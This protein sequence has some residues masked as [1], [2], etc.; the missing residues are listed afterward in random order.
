M[1]FGNEKIYRVPGRIHE[2]LSKPKHIGCVKISSMSL[3]EINIL[4]S[5][6]SDDSSREKNFDSITLSSVVIHF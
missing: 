1:N 5:Y 6:F 2:Q 4:K 3:Q